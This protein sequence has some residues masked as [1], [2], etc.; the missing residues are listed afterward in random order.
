MREREIRNAKIARTTLGY[1]DHGILTC[2][3]HLEWEGGGQGFGGYGLDAWVG[4]RSEKGRRW[5]T[6]YGMEFVAQ[7]LKVVG[8]DAWEKLPGKFVRMEHD[9]GKIYRIGHIT[10]EKWFAPESLTAAF[11]EHNGNLREVAAP[12]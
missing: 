5:G 7:I 3:L 12:V 8:V 6:A 2:F 9:W 11:D 10:D 1:E 4:E